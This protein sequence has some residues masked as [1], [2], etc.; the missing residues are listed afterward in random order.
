LRLR[1]FG[2]AYQITT[3]V[4]NDQNLWHNSAWFTLADA[5]HRIEI[6]WRAAASGQND[7][8]YAL[9][10]D[11]VTQVSHAGLDNDSRLIDQVRLGAVGGIDAGTSGIVY[12]DEFA[13][14]R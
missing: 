4:L 12:F 1:Y 13:S 5:P 9:K 6:N 2:G 11:G 14:W 3:E 8:A 7:G 10:V